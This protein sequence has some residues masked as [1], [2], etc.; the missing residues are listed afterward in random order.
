MN[1]TY[2]PGARG[3]DNPKPPAERQQ[4][5]EL[6]RFVTARVAEAGTGPALPLAA[7]VS[8]LLTTYAHI[9]PF[10]DDMGPEYSTGVA[11]GLG[12]ALRYIAAVWDYHPDYQTYFAPQAPATISEW[13]A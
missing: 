2:L 3:G 1:V 11:D 13:P 8:G 4:N 9:L 10:L 7:G 5:E 12:Q 6:I